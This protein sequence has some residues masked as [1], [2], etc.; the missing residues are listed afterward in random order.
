VSEAFPLRWPPGTLRTRPER[1]QAAKL[2]AA[3]AVAVRRARSEANLLPGRGAVLSLD[4]PLGLDGLPAPE[5]RE[6]QP[7]DP[8]AALYF[9]FE[10]ERHCIACDHWQRVE[11]NI[12]AIAHAIEA[13]RR[14][15]RAG[16]FELVRQAMKGFLAPY[17]AAEAEAWWNVLGVA[18]DAALH[19]AEAAYR[20]RVQ[21]AHPDRGGSA[22]AMIRLNQA[23]GEA[24]LLL[25]DRSW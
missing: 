3:F 17:G 11:D 1:R 15:R 16:G 12:Q 10:G 8:G 5:R 7:D 21:V 25:K 9:N 24:R 2:E 22:E 13:L 23:I 6:V 4:L 14:L 18:Y 19:E 20:A